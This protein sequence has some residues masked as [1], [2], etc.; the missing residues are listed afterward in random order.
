[1]VT[2]SLSSVEKPD[3]RDRVLY[4]RE[5]GTGSIHQHEI[6]IR[7]LGAG[8][9]FQILARKDSLPGWAEA[10]QTTPVVVWRA[11]NREYTGRAVAIDG[12][13]T[14]EVLLH[15]EAEFGADRVR[16]W[17]G[18][19]VQAFE[20][21]PLASGRASYREIVES[22]FD[23]I[24]SSYESSVTS[25]PF[26][27]DLRRTSLDVI[28]RIFR[29]GDRILEIGAG[30]GL[31]TLV[32]ASRGIE[33][34][35]TDISAQMIRRLKAKIELEGLRELVMAR[36]L[37]AGEITQLLDEFGPNSFDGAFST[38]GALNC[39]EDLASFPPALAALLR[40]NSS[41]VFAIWN[42]V[43]LAEFVLSFLARD[44]RRAF[45]RQRNPVPQGLSRYGIPVYAYSFQ[46]F[47]RP[48]LPHF[49]VEHVVG[50]PV[51]V[52]PY[53]YHRTFSHRP[54]SIRVL[55]RLDKAFANRF[56][57]TRFGDHFLVEMRRR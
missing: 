24:A 11:R 35:A 1:M 57:F 48:F 45:A 22:Y 27:A 33:V 47:V 42:R 36:K 52:P 10:L 29:P 15:F 54:E 55:R 21:R 39:E 40:P 9:R 14:G 51:F 19:S 46:S 20:L 18:P 34:V 30:P 53:D 32:L 2:T 44:P 7:F 12:A 6:P 41:V 13:D 4:L 25:N 3:D 5:P 43:C 38:Y 49:Q 26:D 16:D 23:A 50:V 31:E 37:A 8:S 56:P 28:L 17:F